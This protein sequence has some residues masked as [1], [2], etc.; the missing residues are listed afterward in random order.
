MS[1]AKKE[2]PRAL[3]IQEKMAA[4][5]TRKQAEEVA[6]R[7]LAHDAEIA[8]AEAAEAAKAAKKK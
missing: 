5:L 1:D 6:D 3:L 8:K 7:Q 4:G 2:T